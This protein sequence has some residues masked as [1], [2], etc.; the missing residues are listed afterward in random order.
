MIISIDKQDWVIDSDFQ[1]F[2]HADYSNLILYN[3][4]GE[5]ERLLGFLK[6][7]NKNLLIDTI[8]FT[9]YTHSGYLPIN[10]SFFFKNVIVF[11]DK[12]NDHSNLF[13]N[14]KNFKVENIELIETINNIPNNSLVIDI[15][16]KL[17]TN[18][19]T[20]IISN[21]NLELD[22]NYKLWNNY[23]INFNQD[24]YQKFYDNYRFF[25]EEQILNYDNLI[26]LCIM[27]KNAGP[28]FENMLIN[29]LKY[30][31]QWTILDTGST[32]GTIEIINKVLVGKKKGKLYQEPFINF[33]DSR[34]RLLELAGKD[35]KFTLMLDDTY[36]V[37]GDLREFLTEI[38]SDQFADSFTIMIKSD[39]TEYGS[40]RILKSNRNLKY[41]NKIH[42]VI[43]DKNNVNVV[44]P[45]SRSYIIDERFDYMENR[46]MERKKLDLKL[47]YEELE[48]D[49]DNSR[50]FYYLGQTYNLLKDY[51]KAYKWFKAR[52]THPNEGF[53]QEKVD[54]S[55]EMARCA[56]FKLNK[57][58][59]ECEKLYLQTYELDKSRPESLY[60]IGVHYY[61]ENNFKISYEY[62]KKSFEIGYPSHCQYSLK[63]TLS[64]HYCPKF[65][66][67]V[68]YQNNDYQLG[69]KASDFYISYNKKEDLDYKEIISWNKIYKHLNNTNQSLNISQNPIVLFIFSNETIYN[70]DKLKTK[71]N[72]IQNYLS[73][74]FNI[75]IESIENLY[76]I[77]LE[78]SIVS[79]FIF[80]YCEFIPIFYQKNCKEIYLIVEK[81]TNIDLVI[82]N[83]ETLNILCLDQNLLNSFNLIFPSL[84][85]KTKIFNIL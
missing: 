69:E 81:T 11:I 43:T 78:N 8:F 80:N 31:D 9:N 21:K 59:D 61:L 73:I 28:Q 33:R 52:V 84:S 32:D 53:I 12:N 39:D 24:L 30:I 63:P 48:E 67:R 35:C 44:I 22:Y 10:C 70:K 38:R 75:S 74:E 60:F 25:I 85:Y 72:N 42:E 13:E 34:N 36:I 47:L 62:L 79:C 6:S 16:G 57:P 26:N 50:T 51:E 20:I 54:A 29:N 83:E 45:I 66:T 3:D 55:F 19:G 15:D 41:I 14:I 68:C 46:T 40:N 2:N 27:V 71:I 37:K 77:I 23:F 64:F 18:Q 58:W 5:L 65:L 49:P 17:Q 76:K 4:L 1:K 82:P 7:I 56:N